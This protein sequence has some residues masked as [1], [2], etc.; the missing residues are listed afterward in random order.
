MEETEMFNGPNL[1][2]GKAEK[3]KQDDLP[4]YFL[5]FK[6]AVPEYMLRTRIWM[7]LHVQTLYHTVSGMMNYS[8]AIK[9]LYRVVN[10]DVVQRF[11]GNTDRLEHELESMVRQK[12]KFVVSMQRYSKFN[13][14]EHENAEFLLRAYPYTL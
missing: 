13:K 6:S 11:G 12:F 3:S 10:P 14:E 2:T 7:L 9:L 8:K 1:L 5:G 4:F